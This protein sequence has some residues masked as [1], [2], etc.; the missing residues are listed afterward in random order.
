MAARMQPLS[1]AILTYSGDIYSQMYILSH[2]WVNF[3]T[4]T[5]SQTLYVSTVCSTLLHKSLSQTCTPHG[6]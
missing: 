2:N 5:D 4:L 3:L 6:T 1:A